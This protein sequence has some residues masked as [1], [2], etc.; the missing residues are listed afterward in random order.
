[1]MVSGRDF[2]VAS[3]KMVEDSGRIILGASSVE[4]PDCPPVKKYVRGVV[5]VGAWIVTPKD[6][7]SYVQYI[8]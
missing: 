3:Y 4:H 7:G 6:K 2:V 8:S 1:M 5:E